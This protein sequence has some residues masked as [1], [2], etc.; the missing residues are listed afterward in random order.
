MMKA[1]GGKGEH[2][3]TWKLKGKKHVCMYVHF[4]GS[5]Y[6]VFIFKV[7]TKMWCIRQDGRGKITELT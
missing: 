2:Q 5:A 1:S 6:H 7:L 3:T 4:S